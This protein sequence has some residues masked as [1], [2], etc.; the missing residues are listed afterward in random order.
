MAVMGLICGVIA[1]YRRRPA[2]AAQA[3]GVV[4]E[5]VA[6]H[7]EVLGVFKGDLGHSGAVELDD[8]GV[9]VRQQD[10]GVRGDMGLA[11]W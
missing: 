11:Q 8:L 10:G 4:V 2:A 7:R 3:C 1:W 6:R 9:W 5:K